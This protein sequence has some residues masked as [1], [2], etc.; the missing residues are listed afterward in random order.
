MKEEIIRLCRTLQAVSALV[1]NALKSGQPQSL[2]V[3][4]PEQPMEVVQPARNGNALFNFKFTEDTEL[5]G[6]M[7]LRVWV[8][9][10]PGK[11]GEIS[12]DDVA[13]FIAVN[14][15]DRDGNAVHFNGSVGNKRA[16]GQKLIRIEISTP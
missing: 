13:M 2:A 11:V 6:Y 15:L 14:K 9:A 3:E 10:R 12:P 4:R 5:S 16:C 8:E 7:K 1:G